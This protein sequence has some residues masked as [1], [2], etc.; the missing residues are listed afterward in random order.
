MSE[1]TNKSPFHQGERDVQSRLGVRDKIEETGQR[2]IRS[3]LPDQH[4]EFYEQLPYLFIGSVDKEGRPW[5]SVLV[6]RPGFI[7]SPDQ[8]TLRIEAARI[9]G[10]PLNNNL[11]PN[12]PIG[13]LGIQYDVRRRNRLTAKIANFDEESITLNVRLP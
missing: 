10:D 5:A 8:H 11:A 9:D 2:F 13:G 1:Q 12:S 7:K 4:R 3:Y 6:G